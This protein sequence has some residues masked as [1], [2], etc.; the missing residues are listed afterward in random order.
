M[1]HGWATRFSSRRAELS[2]LLVRTDFIIRTRIM[3]HGYVTVTTTQ[4][5]K[6]PEEGTR[7]T[8]AYNP[9]L[10]TI[11]AAWVSSFAAPAV[12]FQAGTP[13][14]AE[15]Y[16]FVGVRFA[17]IPMNLSRGIVSVGTY[18]GFAQ[19]FTAAAGSTLLTIT[20]T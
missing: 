20:R 5:A 11:Q 3:V 9:L 2:R 13:H 18:N 14:A 19:P 16:R 10:P 4:K 1:K 7:I 17:S 12:T 15:H 8:P 6:L